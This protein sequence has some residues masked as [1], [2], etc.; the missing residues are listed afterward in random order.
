V[1]LKPNLTFPRHLPGVTTSP[2]FLAATLEYV[3]DCGATALIGEGDGGYGAWSA[4]VGFAGHGLPELA[5][6]FGAQLINLSTAPS[7]SI[8]V[9]ISPDRERTVSLAGVLTDVDTFITMPVPKIHSNT[10]YSGAVKNQWGCLADN[11]RLRLHPD[12]EQIVWA[13]NRV[14]APRLVLADAQY[15]LDRSGPIVGEAIHMNRVI[16]GTEVLAFD[17]A[18]AGRVMGMRPDAIRHLQYGRALGLRW[19]PDEYRDESTGPVHRFGL[20]H[21]LRTRVV[22]AAFTR[23][24][25]VNLLWFSPAGSVAHRILYALNGNPIAREAA[26]VSRGTD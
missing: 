15:I 26:R 2:A 13:V 16:A 21:T 3:S 20:K 10:V 7:T 6:R 1:L 19:E 9:P 23:Q 22:A 4:D 5:S 12:F 14:V 24:W 11:M 25:A 18:T 17:V 8:S